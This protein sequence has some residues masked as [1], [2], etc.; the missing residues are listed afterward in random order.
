MVLPKQ[1]QTTRTGTCQIHLEIAIKIQPDDAILRW[2]QRLGTTRESEYRAVHNPYLV[3][4]RH[5]YSRRA[6]AVQRQSVNPCPW[7]P[8]H[9]ELCNGKGQGT[10]RRSRTSGGGWQPQEMRDHLALLPNRFLDSGTTLA[11]CLSAP[12][13]ILQQHHVLCRTI[14][15]ALGSDRLYS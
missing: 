6:F 5:D 3:P 11:I 12:E 8:A 13:H 1:R 7:P 15:V 2:R 9:G 10:V 4:M 14:W